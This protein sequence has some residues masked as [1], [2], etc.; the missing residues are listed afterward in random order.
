MYIPSV[1][2]HSRVS[3]AQGCLGTGTHA[4]SDGSH[5]ECVSVLCRLGLS[6]VRPYTETSSEY[7][8]SIRRRQFSDDP[9]QNTNIKIGLVVGIL[10]AAFLAVV[11][12]FLWIYGPSIRFREKKKK[13]RGHKSSSSK[14]S[15]SSDGAPPPF[16]RPH[17]HP[18]PRPPPRSAPP[19][20]P[21]PPARPRTPA[22]DA[23]PADDKP[24]G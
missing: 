1:Y 20:S 10:V 6:P 5:S 16:R 13:H 23:P 11:I 14:S 3:V 18:R 12:A 21:P 7:L 17:P 2:H 19:S 8:G 22:D 4:G 24:A 15:R 9:G